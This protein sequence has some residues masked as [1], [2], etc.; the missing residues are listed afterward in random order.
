MATKFTAFIW[1]PLVFPLATFTG[2]GG[3]LAARLNWPPMVFPLPTFI[4]KVGGIVVQ[5]AKP[6][7]VLPSVLT[8]RTSKVA[9]AAAPTAPS[10]VAP[11]PQRTGKVTFTPAASTVAIVAQAKQVNPY[12][13][14]AAIN[15]FFGIISPQPGSGS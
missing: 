9:T 2:K 7:T 1:P 15:T 8:A 4:G 3:F 13:T 14:R 12:T 5:G 10:M 6:P 11:T